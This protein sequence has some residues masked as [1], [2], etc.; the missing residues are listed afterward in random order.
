MT[1]LLDKMMELYTAGVEPYY[2]YITTWSDT[3]LR[4][5]VKQK[6]NNVWMY[7]ITLPNPNNSATS[8][9][10]TY[11]TV[12]GAGAF[13]HTPVIDWYSKEVGDLMKGRDYY[14]GSYHRFIHLKLGV[15]TVLPD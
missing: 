14:C 1:E 15:V 4:S 13:E 12:V 2:A 6:S 11:C 10:H 9:Y 3:F 5:Y 8:P 7:T